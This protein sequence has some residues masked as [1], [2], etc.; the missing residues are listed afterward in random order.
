MILRRNFRAR[1]LVEVP[2]AFAPSSDEWLLVPLY[3]IFG[4]E[5]LSLSAPGVA[6]LA[7]KPYVALNAE[8]A[9]RLGVEAGEQIKIKLD[10]ATLH[11]F[12]SRSRPSCLWVLR[13]CRLAFP[14]WQESAFPIRSVLERGGQVVHTPHDEPL[15]HRDDHRRA[16]SGVE[17][18]LGAD[19]A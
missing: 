12:P 18:C 13:A 9:K 14:A 19:L 6:E 15:S 3:H 5:E 16:H 4:S 10:G 7:P 11:V 17:H 8:D 2:T 1:I